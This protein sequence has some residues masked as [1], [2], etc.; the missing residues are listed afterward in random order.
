MA[1]FMGVLPIALGFGEHGLNPV[2]LWDSLLW[3]D[4]LYHKS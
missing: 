4:L 2:V 1:V 3:A